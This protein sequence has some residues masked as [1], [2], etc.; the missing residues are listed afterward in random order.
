M[1]TLQDVLKEK[2]K[3]QK[4]QNANMGNPA[5]PYNKAVQTGNPN[6][7]PGRQQI[8]VTP[9][10]QK[11]TYSTPLQAQTAASRKAVDLLGNAIGSGASQTVQMGSSLLKGVP[12]VAETGARITNNLFGNAPV[13]PMQTKLNPSEIKTEEKDGNL[14]QRL[15][16]ALLGEDKET[17]TVELPKTEQDVTKNRF[18]NI[19]NN[20]MIARGEQPV[21][22]ITN[23][24]DPCSD[25]LSQN[26]E[27]VQNFG[28][29]YN[30]AVRPITDAM[31]TAV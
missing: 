30:Q 14:V 17:A 23:W 18:Q 31:D 13:S 29:A 12:K 4:K 9:T 22:Q 25:A 1:A 27:N 5:S 15:A 11:Q 26:V 16:N 19:A 7:Q 6:V 21:R 20:E 2:K 8:S 24:S 28:Q 10:A 3:Q